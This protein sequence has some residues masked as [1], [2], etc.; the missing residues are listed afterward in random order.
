MPAALAVGVSAPDS[1]C[2]SGWRKEKLQNFSVLFPPE[3]RQ[4]PLPPMISLRDRRQQHQAGGSSRI[5]LGRQK[6]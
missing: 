3:Q 2:R 1:G 4:R 6:I 5:T